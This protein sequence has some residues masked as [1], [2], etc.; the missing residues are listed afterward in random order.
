MDTL[1]LELLIINSG[2]LS[3]IPLSIEE[4]YDCR[5]KLGTYKEAI[6]FPP[7]FSAFIIYHSVYLHSR[8]VKKREGEPWTIFQTDATGNDDSLFRFHSSLTLLDTGSHLFHLQFCALDRNENHSLKGA[9]MLVSK[10]SESTHFR[11]TVVR[12]YIRGRQELMW[13]SKDCNT[14]RR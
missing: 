9:S 11:P 4:R 8:A 12:I 14:P 1:I 2:R 3:P 13:V 7:S 5:R 10:Y 6:S